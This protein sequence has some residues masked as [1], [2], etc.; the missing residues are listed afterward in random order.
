MR[1]SIRFRLMLASIFVIFLSL[2]AARTALLVLF[3]R[4]LRR[5]ANIELEADLDQL[6][7][8]L[9]SG[10]DGKVKLSNELADPRFGR[11]FGGRYWQVTGQDGAIMRSRSLWDFAVAA[12]TDLVPHDGIRRLHLDG[13]D[14][15]QLY[16]LARSIVLVDSPSENDLKPFTLLVGMDEAETQ[17][18]SLQFRSDVVM[19]LGA[20]AILLMIAAWLQ[21]S[22]G[23]RPLELLRR[24]LEHI[25]T[26]KANRLET[27]HPAELKPLIAEMNRLLEAQ[28]L[29]VEQARSRSADLAHGLKTPLTAIAV[30][31]EKLKVTGHAGLARDIALQLSRM[32]AHVERELA[33]ARIAANVR[34]ARRQTKVQPIVANLMRTMEKLPG[35]DALEWRSSIDPELAV[36]VDQTDLEEV[37]GNLLD[38]AR[39][40]SRTRVAIGAREFD[41]KVVGISVEDDGN[42]IAP[43]H[44]TSVLHRG[45]RLDEGMPGTGLGLTIVKDMVEAYGGRIELASSGLGGLCVQL[46]LPGAALAA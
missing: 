45:I 4:N 7:A 32:N 40:W 26:G 5:Q 8:L 34:V 37:L 20:L 41:G 9:A 36:F 38:N 28:E 31:L 12:P 11:P 23:L 35:G 22:V 39:K 2:E 1:D 18:L 30:M 44:T 27:N 15:Q 16:A 10:R 24:G 6:A 29:A 14:H 33:R 25:R 17:M 3:D 42:G 43:Q 13:P 19:A 46:S 21:V